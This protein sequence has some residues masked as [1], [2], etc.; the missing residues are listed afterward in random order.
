MA[1]GGVTP[2]RATVCVE[3][4]TPLL[5]SVNVSVAVLVPTAA[6]VNVTLHVQL[7]FVAATVEPLVQVVPPEAMAKSPALAP[8]IV[9]VARCSVVVPVL[10]NVPFSGALVVFT[11]CAGKEIVVG[12]SRTTGAVPLPVNATDCVV[13]GVAPLSSV[14]VS[15]AVRE[16]SAVGVNFTLHVQFPAATTRTA[17]GRPVAQLVPAVTIEK[18]EAFGPTIA[19][20][21]MC[22][23]SVPVLL[24]VP[25]CAVLGVLTSWFPKAAVAVDGV[26]TGAIPVP[27]SVI[28]AGF[29]MPETVMVMFALRAFAAVGLNVTLSVQLEA[30]ATWALTDV[31]QV[32]AGDAKAKSDAFVPV[33]AMLVTFSGAPPLFVIVTF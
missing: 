14:N 13:P 2:V 7:P 28:G 31:G 20:A 17:V 8:V 25:F 9:T 16:P 15:D 21:V 5:S 32:V 33:I 18:S 30:G 1:A 23:T 29:A 24:R 6:G 27:E 3:P 26:A 22:K 12:E 19:T 10:V 11:A 4:G